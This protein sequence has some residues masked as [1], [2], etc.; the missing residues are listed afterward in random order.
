[1]DAARIRRSLQEAMLVSLALLLGLVPSSWSR[2]RGP[3][4][5]VG[6]IAVHRAPSVARELISWSVMRYEEAGLDLPP[7]EVFFHDERDGCG[8][9]L[10]TTVAGRIDLCV[11]LAMEPGPQRIVL[12]ELAHAWALANLDA[13]RQTRFLE[14]RGLTSWTGRGV[15]WDEQGREQAAEIVAW[16]LGDGTMLPMIAGDTGADALNEAFRSLTGTRAAG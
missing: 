4:F 9:Y 7:T 8:G 5:E 15:P 11:R 6:P 12:H 10:G 14:L 1:M 2:G 16:G 3:V 13:G